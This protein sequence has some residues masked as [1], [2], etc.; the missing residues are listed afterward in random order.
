VRLPRTSG[1]RFSATPSAAASA[2]W[3]SPAPSHSSRS[4]GGTSRESTAG[5]SSSAGRCVLSR[6]TSRGTRLGTTPRGRTRDSAASLPTRSMRDIDDGPGSCQSVWP[7]TFATWGMIARYRFCVSAARRNSL[8]LPGQPRR[9]PPV[10]C[11]LPADQTLLS[12]PVVISR[13]AHPLSIAP[14]AGTDR[15]TGQPVT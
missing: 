6:P 13:P 15:Q 4:S 7:S 3:A 10:V 1:G 2:R 8:P 5:G 14:W 12:A 9:G 11:P